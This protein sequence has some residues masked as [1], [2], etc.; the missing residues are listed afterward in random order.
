MV[1]EYY[2]P[3]LHD[4]RLDYICQILEGTTIDGEGNL[5]E[6]WQDVTIGRGDYSKTS[7]YDL[8]V[9]VENRQ[10]RNQFLTKQDICDIGWEYEMEVIPVEK[11]GETS[12]HKF[13]RGNYFLIYDFVARVVMITITMGDV[14][15]VCVQ[16]FDCPSVNELMYIFSRLNLH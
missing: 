6:N 2:T 10:I 3:S 8:S 1:E 13:T 5:V 12:L 9:L 11:N 7:Y 16:R 14:Y 4:V 15:S